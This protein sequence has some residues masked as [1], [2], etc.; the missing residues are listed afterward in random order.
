MNE[1]T[2]EKLKELLHYDEN[3][4][5]FTWKKISS[6]KSRIKI[7]NVAGSLKI[8]GYITIQI[9]RK[10]YPAH[11]LAWF[12]IHGVWPKNDIDHINHN[13]S[14][15]RIENLRQATRSENLQNLIKANIRSKLGIIGVSFSD[16]KYNAKIKLNGK[17]FWLGS[18]NTADEASL[19]YITAK[20]KLH[21]F[22]TI[23]I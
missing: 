14:D 23:D 17:V 6:T 9:N 10:V 13:R 20:K 11:R 15:N 7:G 5:V 2:Q 4:G 8:D 1:L 12:Y 3:T 16:G 22:N 21:P 19:A 18:F